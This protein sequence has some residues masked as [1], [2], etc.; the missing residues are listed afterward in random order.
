[1]GMSNAFI[2]RLP[3]ERAANFSISK[4]DVALQGSV[5]ETFMFRDISQCQ[6]R[7]IFND[8]CKSINF[9]EHGE[10]ICELN[11]KAT[12]TG[13]EDKRFEPKLTTRKGWKYMS[14]NYSYPLVIIFQRI[15]C[16]N[17]IRYLLF[18]N[19]FWN[20]AALLCFSVLYSIC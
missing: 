11:N 17:P 13:I 10:N 8:D 12:Y 6:S 7:C 2:L 1:M 14:T 4:Q 19:T 9:Q 18:H 20:D 16:N 5:I 3:C 15:L